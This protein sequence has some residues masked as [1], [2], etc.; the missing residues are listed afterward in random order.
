MVISRAKALR[1]KKKNETR[2]V[3]L[4]LVPKIFDNIICWMGFYYEYIIGSISSVSFCLERGWD[5]F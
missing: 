3:Q 2:C 1:E 4:C 5:F